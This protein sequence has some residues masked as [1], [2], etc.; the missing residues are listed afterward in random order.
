MPILLFFFIYNF[1]R[2]SM[3][4]T[5]EVLATTEMTISGSASTNALLCSGLFFDL[6]IISNKI[7]DNKQVNPVKSCYLYES[8]ISIMANWEDICVFVL[9]FTKPNIIN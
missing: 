7:L 6:C 4:K 1:F 8:Y 9:F 5:L 2:F 3:E